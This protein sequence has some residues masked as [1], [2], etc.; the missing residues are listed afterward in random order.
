VPPGARAL[1]LAAA[2]DVF[3]FAYTAQL[4][5]G[6]YWDKLTETQRKEFVDAFQGFIGKAYLSTVDIGDGQTVSYLDETID[7]NRATVKSRV[8]TSGGSSIP[9]D[10][11][12]VLGNGSR[13]RLYDVNVD[14]MSL[15]SNYRQQF[16]RLIRASSYDD[17]VKKLRARQSAPSASPQ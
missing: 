15:V 1:V 14:G 5:L 8:T 3:D 7:G 11:R 9:I 2:D 16:V 10:F 17:L 12:M 6:S 4:T 13:W